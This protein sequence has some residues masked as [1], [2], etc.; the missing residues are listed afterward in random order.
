MFRLLTCCFWLLAFQASASSFTAM[1]DWTG[2]R[3]TD[4][5]NGTTN[6]TRSTFSDDRIVLAA[7]EDAARFVA[8]DG[9]QRGARLEAALRHIRHQLP[10]LQQASDLQLARAILMI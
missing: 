3:L 9:Q 5:T 6:L 1:T 4:A 8:S 7:R 10:G 2:E